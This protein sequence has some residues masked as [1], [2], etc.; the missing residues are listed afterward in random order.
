[1][2][3]TIIAEIGENHYGRWDVC[4]GMVREAA[5]NGATI[6]KFQSYTADQFGRDHE[7]YEAFDSVAMPPEVHFEMQALCQEVGIRFLSSSFTLRSSAFLIDKMGCDAVKLA[8]S[9][10]VHL[11][12]LDYVNSRADQVKTV[13]LSTGMATLEEVSAAV[14]RLD[15]IEQLYLLQCT[16]Q[17]PTEDEHVNLRAMVALKQTFPQHHVGL[18][19]HSRGIEACT[20]AATLGAEVLEKHF[21][22]HTGM[23]GDD[24]EGGMTPEGLA[25]LVRRIERIEVMLGSSEKKPIPAEERAMGAMRTKLHEVGFD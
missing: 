9:Q 24:H 11:E 5:A 18:S 17:Y 19:D 2:Q 21:T 23:P 22:Y 1:M 8:S 25:E 7:W 4:A 14:A 15:R 10:V 16:S 13:Y 12:Q 20:A 6:A 3:T